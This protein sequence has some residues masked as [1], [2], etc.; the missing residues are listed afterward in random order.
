MTVECASE[1]PTADAASVTDEADNCG[2]DVTVEVSDSDNGGSGC[3][4][5]AKVITRTF[6]LTDCGGLATTV[7]QTITVEDQTAPTG[8]APAD[9]TVECASEVPVANAASVT[10][11]ADNCGGDVTVEVADTDNGGSGCNGDALIITRTYTMTD[12]GGLTTSVAQTI[13]VEDQTAPTGTA[14]ADLTFECE[15][16]VPAADAASVTDEADNCGGDVTVEVV[17]R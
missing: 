4:G 5:D 2:G 7:A 10:D 6:T 1:V 12:C 17:R 3:N 9:M 13:K 8:S 11:E 14:P 15:S 16:E